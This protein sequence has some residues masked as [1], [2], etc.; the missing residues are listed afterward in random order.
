MSLARCLRLA[1]HLAF[2]VFGLTPA[3]AQSGG[4]FVNGQTL[5]AAQLN[6]AFAQKLDVGTPIPTPCN[7]TNNQLFYATGSPIGV[8]QGIPTIPSG[9]LTTNTNGQPSVTNIIPSGVT[10]ANLAWNQPALNNVFMGNSGSTYATGQHNTGTGDYALGG[11]TTGSFNTA[12][13]F[14]ALMQNQTGY[15]NVAVGWEALPSLV[16]GHD[17][18]V[19][20]Y[21]AGNMLASGYNNV[22]LGQESLFQSQSAHDNV[23]V[24]YEA[25]LSLG[26]TIVATS[27]IVGNSYT[28]VSVGFGGG[29]DFTLC[30]SPNNTIGTIFTAS[31]ACTGIGRVSPNPS[32][33]T[34]LGT[35]AGGALTDANGNICIGSGA[36]LG[37]TTGSQ[38]TLIGTG[39][40]SLPATTSK[41]IIISD[42]A[43]D[44]V[45]D[46]NHDTAGK[47][48]LRT[49]SA[50]NALT[51]TSSATTVAPII[52]PG[53]TGSDTNLNL[54]VI[55]K[56]TGIVRIGGAGCTGS[57][58][59]PVTCNGQNGRITTVSLTTA[60]S[61]ATTYTINDSSVVATSN[62]QCT[63]NI[64]TGAGTPVVTQC[65]PGAGTI[66]ATIANVNTTTALNSTVGLSFLVP[67]Q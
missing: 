12:N 62:V 46:Y 1:R 61:A 3:W 55:G 29:T 52:T 23:T 63:I 32:L 66:V 67:N 40:A 21:A 6:A 56:G 45:F 16:S 26:P 18:V 11:L 9:V 10:I 8:C 64:Y 38:N 49:A 37:I 48:T 58:A 44:N 65:T 19:A 15:N 60:A 28:I 2:I 20:G 27:I 51:V 22:S 17:N 34:L 7:A 30:G 13:G 47:L 50:V 53:G 42:G 39:M 14:A 24:G 4:G 41:A 54:D 36:C 33:H 57:G 25:G 43:T 31:M 59:S 5:T 35:N